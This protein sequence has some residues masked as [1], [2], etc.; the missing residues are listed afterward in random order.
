MK[1]HLKKARDWF[2]EN[3]D[4]V[5][6]AYWV[7]GAVTI[8]MQGGWIIA[9]L[10]LCMAYHHYK[11]IQHQKRVKRLHQLIDLQTDCIEELV[12]E[13]GKA[14]GPKNVNDILRKYVERLNE[15][16]KQ[17]PPPKAGA[18]GKLKNFITSLLQPL[19]SE[20]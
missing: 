14:I 8:T 17:M 7:A 13:L 1:D 5:L 9:P 19:G 10:F 16:K 12:D 18:S 11:H 15:Q 20:A 4:F 6:T 2:N 3:A